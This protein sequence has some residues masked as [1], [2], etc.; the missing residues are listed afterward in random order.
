MK[1]L[2]KKL[3][4]EQRYVLRALG[5][6]AI[7]AL[8]LTWFLEYRYFRNQMWF[9][10]NFIFEHPIGYLLN[11][12]LMWLMLL[13]LWGI[14]GKP[15][16]SVC[17]M[18][19]LIVVLTYIHINKYNSRQTPLLP[20]DFQL[21]S[22]VS[23]LTK[24]VDYG[25]IIRMVVAV[26]LIVGLTILF[27][28][29]FARKLGLVHEVRTQ[30]FINKHMIW[31]RL[32]LIVLSAAAFMLSTDFARHNNG[33]RYEDLPILGTR[34]TVW[35]QNRNYDDNGFIVGFLYNF[36]KLQLDTPDVYSEETIKNIRAQY[37]EIAEKKNK[38]RKDPADE[39][40]SVVI[41][42][43]ESF[44]D[45]NL[46]Y[47]GKKFKDFYPYSGGEITPNLRKIQQNYPSGHMYSLDYGGG[48][49]NIEFEVF[50][51]LTNYWVNTVPYTALIP[52]A[53]DIP[54]VAQ[55]LKEKNFETLV[56]H[57][58]NGGMYKRNISLAHEGFNEFI[59]VNEMEFQE[60]EGGS[61]YVNDRSAYQETIKY[62]ES[63]D[64]N[65]MIGLITMQNHTPY[66]ADNYEKLDYKLLNEDIPAERKSQ[67][68]TYF[69]S[70]H[71]SD[72]YLGEFIDELEKLDKKVVVL[73]YGDHSAGLFD[74]LNS[75]A[76]Q[77][78]R[79][80]ARL[81]PYFIYTNYKSAASTRK[82]LPTT[83]PNCLTNTMLNM[84]KWQKT[85][86]YYLVDKVCKEEPILTANYLGDRE[87]SNPE[88]L[89]SYELVT[90]DILGGKK[91]WMSD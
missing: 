29:K 69:Q 49:A 24:F 2:R 86:L 82:T 76:E 41:I 11:S 22:E 83:T 63:T 88:L 30:N 74:E 79:D 84:L 23:S 71:T 61:E 91:Y 37:T 36:Q 44:Y 68:E 28:K 47:K 51:S 40:V 59:T 54:S 34:F 67:I 80:M 21:A 13:F 48:T 87:L 18:W 75:N 7:V 31:V 6:L 32:S 20:E 53:G 58:Y 78:V 14:F 38:K 5:F 81:T 46:S 52:K 17:V 8:V 3:T 77:N 16:T 70:L 12:F 64:Q 57:P 50:T 72:Q 9:A 65:Q 56:I 1:S 90:Y 39:D 55:T 85:P 10:W 19:S 45:P 60:H 43:N 89:R 62:L 26:L 15:S 35:D 25:S 73:W 33:E 27:E 42:L 4:A 66:I